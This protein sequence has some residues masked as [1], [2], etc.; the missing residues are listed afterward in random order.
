MAEDGKMSLRWQRDV[1][2]LATDPGWW[3]PG[4]LQL[5]GDLASANESIPGGIATDFLLSAKLTPFPLGCLVIPV[6]LM[7]FPL[8]CL[9]ISAT[10]IILQSFRKLANCACG[11]ESRELAKH[12]DTRQRSR[13]CGQEFMQV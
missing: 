13:R 9:L 12:A 2:W 8:G 10:N 7:P 6:K 3:L 4:D 5:P 1:S 11:R